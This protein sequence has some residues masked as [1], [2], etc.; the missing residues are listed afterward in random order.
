LFSMG[1]WMQSQGVGGLLCGRISLSSAL[2]SMTSKLILVPLFMVGLAKAFDFNDEVGRAAVL[3][4][5]LPIS[6]ASFSLA[7]RYNI[8]EEIL[9]QNVALGTALILPTVLVWNIVMDSLGVF[10]LSK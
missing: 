1:I 2:L 7:S 5:S 6:M 4:A 3:I 10:P 9:S 8:G